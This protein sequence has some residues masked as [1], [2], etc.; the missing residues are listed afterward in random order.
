MDPIRNQGFQWRS[1][2]Y[3]ALSLGLAKRCGYA[4]EIQRKTMLETKT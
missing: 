2:K 1:T 3:P 4:K